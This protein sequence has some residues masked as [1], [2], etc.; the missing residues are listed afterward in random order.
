MERPQSTTSALTSVLRRQHPTT[1]ILLGAWLILLG[2]YSVVSLTVAK[3]PGLT[4]YGDIFQ[5]LAALFACVGL[6]MNSFSR[7]SRTRAFWLLMA[8]GCAAWLVGQFIWTYFEVVLRQNVPNP[9][10]GDVI[11][12]LHPVPMMWAL[13]LRPHDRRDD[14]NFH[15]GYMDFS[16]LLVWWVYLYLFVVIPWQY[17]AP[18]VHAYGMSY[19]HL[20]AVENAVLAI[21]LAFLVGR[22]KGAWREIYAHLFSASILYAAGSYIINRAI[23]S[24]DYY[25]GSPYDLPLMASFVWFATAGFV[26]YRLKPVREALPPPREGANRWPARVAMAAVVS[27]PLMAL[28]SLRYSPNRDSVRLFRVGV[29]QVTLLVVSI[30]AF[31]RQR[32]VDHDRLRLIES[33][34]ESFENLKL[35]QAQMVQTEKLVSLGQLAAGAAHE[36]NNPLTG[37]L[38]YSDL[39]VDDPSLGD[40]QRVVADKIRTLAR[41]IKTLVTSLLSFARRVPTEKAHLDLNQVLMSALHLSNLDL[42][43]KKIEIE[44]LAD[45]EL[46]PVRGDANQILQVFFNLMDNAVDALEEVGGGKLMI[47]TSHD[48]EKVTI[49]FSDSGPGIKSPHQVFDPFF[50]TKPVGKGTG[51]GLSICYGIVQEHGGHIEC[52]NRS[53]G[54]A[55]FMVQLPIVLNEPS[56]FEAPAEVASKS[57]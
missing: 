1:W 17:I 31:F 33:S 38:G 36:I 27:I 7:E 39:L 48:E 20:A 10:I 49:E 42:R 13:V 53:E 9:F 43:G 21:G 52:F 4:T 34:R 2:S 55:T 18:D 30:L 28:W 24:Q 45:M 16:L 44:T 19:D 32:L 22:S 14:V 35:F 6:M 25:T 5:C 8:F 41:R 47:R 3:G 29:T 46:P 11:L 12:F 50:T 57:N 23:D 15:I 40:R 56:P 51:L 26:A 37:I 54:G